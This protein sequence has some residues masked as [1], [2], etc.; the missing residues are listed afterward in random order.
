MPR[1]SNRDRIL[2]ALEDELLEGGPHAPSLDAVAA[3]ASVSKGGVLYH[4]PS[5]DDLLEALLRRW[6]DRAEAELERIAAVEGVA[7]AWLS[8]SSPAPSSEASRDMRVARS[9]AALIRT[10]SSNP[11]ADAVTTLN[12]RWRSR[13]TEEVHDPVLA[14]IIRLV[15][16]GLYFA[17]LIGAPPPDPELLRSVRERLVAPARGALAPASDGVVGP[18]PPP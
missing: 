12:E 14:E 9:L 4:F 8:T 13:L 17:H 11:L 5:K 18:V 1:P 15:G 6:V 16:D 7:A 3:R 10:S 2:D